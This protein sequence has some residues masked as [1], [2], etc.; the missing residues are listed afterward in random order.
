[1][2]AELGLVGCIGAHLEKGEEWYFTP[3]VWE[4]PNPGA[5][6]GAVV[7]KLMGGVFLCTGRGQWEPQRLCSKGVAWP[8]CVRGRSRRRGVWLVL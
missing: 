6:A 8:D 4:L 3:E 1:M 2:V 5:G 7:E